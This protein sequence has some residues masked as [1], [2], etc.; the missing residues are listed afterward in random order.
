MEGR[1]V[2]GNGVRGGV[3]NRSNSFVEED[4]IE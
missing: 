2:F 3:G 4:G 1:G